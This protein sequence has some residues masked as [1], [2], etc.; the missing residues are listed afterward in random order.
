MAFENRIHTHTHTHYFF[1]HTFHHDFLHTNTYALTH[2]HTHTFAHTQPTSQPKEN[3]APHF[4]PPPVQF[5]L[6]GEQA[7]PP[8]CL[9]Q[10]QPSTQTTPRP[11]GKTEAAYRH[12]ELGDGGSRNRSRRRRRKWRRGLWVPPWSSSLLPPTHT[13]TDGGSPPVAATT[14]RTYCLGARLCECVFPFC[15]RPC[16]ESTEFVLS[17]RR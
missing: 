13:H 10:G 8:L 5:L 7:R 12:G 6:Y 15:Q 4:P 3:E 11:W 9:L 14:G 16:C 2:I 17:M 1:P